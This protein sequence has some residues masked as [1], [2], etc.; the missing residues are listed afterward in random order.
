[1]SAIFSDRILA[2]NMIKSIQEQKDWWEALKEKETAAD[3]MSPG[4]AAGNLLLG[5]NLP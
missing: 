1:M 4:R 5:A 3:F 2:A